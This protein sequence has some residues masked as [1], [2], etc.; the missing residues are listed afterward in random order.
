VALL[1]FLLPGLLT[2]VLL[3]LGGGA[4]ALV[5]AFGAGLAQLSRDPVVRGA[6]RVYVEV[7]RGTSLL[8]QLFWFAFALPL[9]GVRI[10]NEVI[11]VVIP[12]LNIGAYGA[13][14]VRSAIRAVPEGQL[15]AAV[16]LNLTR[17]QRMVR[18]ILPQALVAM[19]PTFG[20]LLVELLKATAL[21]STIFIADMMRQAMFWR[22]HTGQLMPALAAI[23]VMYFVLASIVLF[24]VRRLEA[25]VG[26][27][28]HDARRR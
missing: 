9:V 8:V 12:G 21:V 11:A 18:I 27:R 5:S 25:V 22:D 16:A 24:G 1:E 28:W 6:A 17:R 26:G 20:N 19:L 4:V 13:E 2:T 3:F 7:F 15:A 14:V 23:L 10:P